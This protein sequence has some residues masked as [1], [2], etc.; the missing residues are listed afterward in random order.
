MIG[1]SRRYPLPAA[2]DVPAEL[3]A[4]DQWVC[5]LAEWK[6]DAKGERKRTKVL[7]DPLT[8]FR[9]ASTKPST[10]ASFDQ[11]YQRAVRDFDGIGFVFGPDDPYCGIDLDHCIS[12][13]TGAIAPWALAIVRRLATY[14]EVSVSGT[15]VH[16]L[17]RARLPGG[18]INR[19]PIEV[20]DRGRFFTFS[21]RRLEVPH[22]EHD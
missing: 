17:A 6:T 20:Y 18:G 21:G 14:A 5:W 8:G 19:R 16:L 2:G 10:W 11:A 15:G 13:D 12:L 1:H 9:A 4:R 3:R 7:Y 22:D